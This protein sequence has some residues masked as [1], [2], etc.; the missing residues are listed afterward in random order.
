LANHTDPKPW[1]VCRE[2]GC[3]ALVGAHVGRVLSREI[4]EIGVPMPSHEQKAT[5]RLSSSRQTSWDPTRSETPRMH[6]NTLA[7]NRESSCLPAA[8]GAVGGIGKSED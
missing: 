7:E 6:G 1:A 3:Q 8:D 4:L 5:P 2:A